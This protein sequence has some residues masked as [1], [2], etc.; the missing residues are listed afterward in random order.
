ME[1]LYTARSVRE[2]EQVALE[3]DCLR[4]LPCGEQQ[5]RRAQEVQLALARLG[6][7]HHRSVKIPD[8]LIAACAEAA[9]AI[10]WHYDEDY[11]RVARITG[12]PVEWIAPRGSL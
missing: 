8:L 9:G 11:E 3:L 12:Q 10:I 1:V 4:Q 7:L 6:G 2:Y 5:F